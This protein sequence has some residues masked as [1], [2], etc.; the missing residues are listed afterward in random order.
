MKTNQ[1]LFKFY[2]VELDKFSEFSIL[3]EKE[4]KYLS[5]VIRP[6]RD[7]IETISKHG[8]DER[9]FIEISLLDEGE[10][11]DIYSPYFKTNTMY[12][13]MKEGKSYTL[14]ELGL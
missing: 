1:V 7:K 2:A 4:R 8:D 11:D 14:E 10:R 13:G 9:E 5:A 12:K 3:N 6:F